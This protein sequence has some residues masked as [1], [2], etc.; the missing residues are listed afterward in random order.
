MIQ[1]ILVGIDHCLETFAIEHLLQ[2]CPAPHDLG[3]FIHLEP[4]QKLPLGI[5]VFLGLGFCLLA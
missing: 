4:L 1:R 2:P 3:R 5:G